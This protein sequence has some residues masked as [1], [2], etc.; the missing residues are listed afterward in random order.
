[1]AQARR[2]HFH[3]KFATAGGA[4]I[5]FDDFEG[6]RFRVGRRE[7]GLAKNGGLNAHGR[8]SRNRKTPMLGEIGGRGN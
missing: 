2:R 3:E 4:K 5:E 7:A 6:F 1:M 8:R